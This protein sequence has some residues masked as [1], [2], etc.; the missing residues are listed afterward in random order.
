MNSTQA[1]ETPPPWFG[2]R[3][4]LGFCANFI[5]VGLYLPYFPVWLKAQALSPSQISAVLSMSL[6]I[7][8]L[9]SGQVM[10]FADRYRD[11]AVLLSKL[12]V[13]AALSVLLYL[14][15]GSF[16]PI[17]FVTLLYNFF[18]NPVLPLL[19]AITLAGVRR[20]DADYGRIRIW[21]S[22][23]FV[24]ANLGGGWLLASG[25]PQFLLYAI[26][27]AMVLG[28]AVSF[29]IPRIGR[30]Q[31]ASSAQS[32]PLTRR[33]LLS[34][35]PFLLVLAASGLGQASHSFLYGFGSIHWQALGFSGGLIGLLWAIGV[36][37]EILLF[38]YSRAV[39]RRLSPVAVIAIGCCGGALRW[40]LFPYIDGEAAFLA[41]QILHGLSFGAVHIGLMHYIMESVPEENL[42][43]AQGVGFVLGGAAMG[44]GVFFSGPL[45]AAA[46]AKGFLVMTV[47]CLAALGLLALN[48]L[49]PR[50]P[51]AAA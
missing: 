51:A 48:R 20:F 28:A 26:I 49:S 22:L 30:R 43:A 38:Q 41:L 10:S 13:A 7:R 15:T 40:V 37:A 21:G 34:N 5:F 11:R 18:F 6:V 19:D 4:A 42:G 45:Y 24:L 35:R 12:Y 33:K 1:F 39:F 9:A 31:P 14:F 47:V 16:W 46:G 3:M 36:F 44:I 32:D 17:L 50:A 29:A 2:A 25:E 23:I 8:V 27:S